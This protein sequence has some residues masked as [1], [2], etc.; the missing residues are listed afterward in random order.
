MQFSHRTV[1]T[2]TMS[3]SAG[4]V[5][6]VERGLMLRRLWTM[7]GIIHFLPGV[8]WQATGPVYPTA[9]REAV[10][11][12]AAYVEDCFRPSSCTSLVVSQTG[13]RTQQ[14][15]RQ[16]CDAGNVMC[17]YSVSIPLVYTIG[18]VGTYIVYTSIP[19]YILYVS[20]Q[21]LYFIYFKLRYLNNKRSVRYK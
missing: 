2:N 4:R 21:S 12:S 6:S 8:C 3:P 10:A 5:R 20:R 16:R 9:I 7:C 13:A 14:V 15:D 1:D 17:M 18:H 11:R 19:R